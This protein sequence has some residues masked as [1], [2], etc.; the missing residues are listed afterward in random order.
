MLP[1]EAVSQGA[2]M[3]RASDGTNTVREDVHGSAD[4]CS[5]SAGRDPTERR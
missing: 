3:Q 2:Q 4:L 5:V 1:P